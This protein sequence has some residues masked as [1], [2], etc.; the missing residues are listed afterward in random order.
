[1]SGTFLGLAQNMNDPK[2]LA[3]AT[4]V[5]QSDINSDTAK[6]SR[7]RICR[8]PGFTGIV[9]QA[10]RP[11]PQ[12]QGIN[13]HSWPIGKSIYHS[14]Q[15]KL[16]KRFANGLLFRVFYTRSKLL[17]NAADNGY[18]NSASSGTAKPDRCAAGA[19]HQ[20]RR[21]AEHFRRV[22]VVRTAVR[23]EPAERSREEADLGLDPERNSSL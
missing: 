2:I 19:V 16:D 20:R 23:Q 11:W 15:V 4:R 7:H 21:C 9:A 5:L 22:V 1:M 18:N 13:W 8:M 6:A 10:L 3:L 17:N 12:Y 14:F